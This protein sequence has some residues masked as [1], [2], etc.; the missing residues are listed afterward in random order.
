MAT[1]LSDGSDHGKVRIERAL[2]EDG[3]AA[4]ALWDVTAA[5]VVLQEAPATRLVARDAATGRLLGVAEY[6][7][8]FPP[9]DV[10]FAVAVVPAQRRRGI[11]TALLRTLARVALR[12]GRRNL[13]TF[14]ADEDIPSWQLI[15]AAGIPVRIY[16]VDD[17]YYVELDLGPLLQEPPIDD[18]EYAAH[19]VERRPEV[20]RL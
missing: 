19:S 6:F 20:S 10:L 15:R 7:R 16:D 13:C 18:A 17:G 4:D 5:R 3:E 8:T 2:P 14:I 1:T 12:D 11:G 9:E